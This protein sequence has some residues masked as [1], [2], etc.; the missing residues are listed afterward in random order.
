MSF[1]THIRETAR[2]LP[3][4]EL[5]K[6]IATIWGATVNGGLSEDEANQL[7]G[8]L[9]LLQKARPEPRKSPRPRPQRPESIQRRRMLSSSGAMPPE[10]ANYFTQGERSALTIIAREVQQH[11]RCARTIGEIA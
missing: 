11:G 9:R 2:R 5:P 4:E 8:E 7:D 1:A 6:L 3:R 10:I